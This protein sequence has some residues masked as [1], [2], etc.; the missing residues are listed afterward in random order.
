MERLR[1]SERHDKESMD[2]SLRD[3]ASMVAHCLEHKDDKLRSRTKKHRS[4]NC[5][6]DTEI[7][8]PGQQKGHKG[9]KMLKKTEERNSKILVDSDHKL[10]SR[11]IEELSVVLQRSRTLPK[12]IQDEQMIQKEIK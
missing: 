12:D 11:V 7:E 5:L 4:L 8:V 9:M 6:E 3:R 2:S 1:L 10:P